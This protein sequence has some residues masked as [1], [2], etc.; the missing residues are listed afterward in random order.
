[1]FKIFDRL[2]SAFRFNHLVEEKGPPKRKG[3]KQGCTVSLLQLSLFL[4][5]VSE[6]LH[7]FAFCLRLMNNSIAV[8]ATALATESGIIHEND[9]YSEFVPFQ[10][11]TDPI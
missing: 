11:G 2:S 7:D 1:V 8:T 4:V 10:A 3:I 9:L 5:C 6:I